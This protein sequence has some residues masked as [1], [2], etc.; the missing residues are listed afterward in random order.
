MPTT[1]SMILKSTSTQ[2]LTCLAGILKKGAD[3]AAAHKIDEAVFVNL[4]LFPDMF[5]LSRQV[6]I[7]ADQ[8]ARGAARLSGSDIPSFPDI[9]TTFAQLIERTQKA[10]AFVMAASS[11]AIDSRTDTN[12]TVPIGGGNE[13]TL[14]CGAFLQSFTLPNFY[15]HA[16]TTYNILRHNGV[17]LGK[18]DFLRPPA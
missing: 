6:Q 3:H 18:G 15:F 5:P 2:M 10:H 1:T 13:M 11:E 12:I 7:A 9:E 8:L 16:A 14:T 4:R 17:V